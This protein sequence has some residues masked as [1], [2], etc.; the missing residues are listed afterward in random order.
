[1]WLARDNLHVIWI[2]TQID[3][4]VYQQFPLLHVQWQNGYKSTSLEH[5]TQNQT[6]ASQICCPYLW[7]HPPYLII[8]WGSCAQMCVPHGRT[9]LVMPVFT[10]NSIH[11]Y[12]IHYRI[13]LEYNFYTWTGADS[14]LEGQQ[15]WHWNQVYLFCRNSAFMWFYVLHIEFI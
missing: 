9:M 11:D 6:I 15:N 7:Y 2:Q 8:T 14:R 12:F 5:N 10:V 13:W 1:M 4:S 3:Q